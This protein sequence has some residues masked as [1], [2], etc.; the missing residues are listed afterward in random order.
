MTTRD[1][2]A[3]P[4]EIR[5]ARP[6]DAALLTELAHAAKRHWRYADELIRLWREDL[7]V[8]PEFIDAHAVECAV[9][10]SRIVGFYALSGDGPTR[11]LEHMW[12]DPAYMG[13]GVGRRLLRHAVAALRAAGCACLEIASD[14]NA[15]GFYLKYGAVRVGQVPARP[16]G[17]TLPLLE[18]RIA[19]EAAVS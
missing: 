3:T 8:T 13:R 17:R 2:A 19:P 9:F 14:P 16:E 18:L 5:G 11:E 7:T 10:G 1:D 12:V 4:L 6:A 15:E